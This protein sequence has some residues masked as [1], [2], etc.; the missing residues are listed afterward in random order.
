VSAPAGGQALVTL[1]SRPGCHLCE[2]ARARLE[3]LRREGLR[4]ELCELDIERD[5]RLHSAY[6]ERIPVVEVEGEVIS[7]LFLDERAL[8]TRLDTVPAMG[9]RRTTSSGA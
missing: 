5:E 1:Y 4:F 9:V 6:L 7:E 3:A 8:R 2:E